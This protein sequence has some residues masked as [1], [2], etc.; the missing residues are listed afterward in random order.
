MVAM[1]VNISCP[2]HHLYQLIGMDKKDTILQMI[3]VQSQWLLSKVCV[4][5]LTCWDCGF[6]SHRVNGFL[7]LVNVVCWQVEVSAL[8][9]SLVQRSPAECG[10]SECDCEASI[11]RP[12]C[13][14]GCCAMKK[15]GLILKF[16]VMIHSCKADNFKPFS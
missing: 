15:R 6:E 5:Q 13:T 9:Q 4:Q 16:C 1:V 12:W 3:L 11:M 10:V 14:S 7:S 8:G 2:V